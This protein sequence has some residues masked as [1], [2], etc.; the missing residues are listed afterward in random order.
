L[1][2]FKNRNFARV[3]GLLAVG[4]MVGGC[5]KSD[6]PE[7]N[8]N[9]QVIDSVEFNNALRLDRGQQVLQRLLLEHAIIQ[10]AQKNKIALDGPELKPYRDQISVHM[11]DPGLRKIAE[12]ELIARLLLRKILLKDTSGKRIR[13]LYDMFKDEL[14]LYEIHALVAGS[15]GE[16]NKAV[17]ALRS[18]YPFA[19]ES[20]K[21]S[22]NGPLKRR[23]GALGAMS[24]SQIV[25]SLGPEVAAAV[26]RLDDNGIAPIFRGRE[27]F[28]VL[29][30]DHVRAGFSELRVRVQDMIVEGHAPLYL[31]DLMKSAKISSKY[32]A[33]AGLMPATNI[34]DDPIFK[35]LQEEAPAEVDIGATQI[36]GDK[37]GDKIGA[38]I[39][40]AVPAVGGAETPAA[41]A[42]Q[43]VGSEVGSDLGLKI[44]TLEL[45]PLPPLP[46]MTPTA[47]PKP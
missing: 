7:A 6:V 24:Y 8:I 32:I 3:L 25:S 36:V 47:T 21:Y 43:P 26:A 44:P 28:L 5:S 40:V 19:D 11:K 15:M 31:S 4:W 13:E 22:N 9:G 42:A 29:Q 35:P 30:V 27:G 33:D 37:L 38:D 1:G 14:T 45:P 20:E 18:N 10:D 41:A 2:I 46:K 16:A 34:M 17:A 39:G 23:K 12:Q